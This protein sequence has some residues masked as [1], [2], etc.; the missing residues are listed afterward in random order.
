MTARDIIRLL[1]QK[2]RKDIFQAEVKTG[3]T[4]GNSGLL[5]LDGWAMKH[6]WANPLTIGYE[7][8]VSR[9]DF[10]GDDKW[11]LYRQYCDEFY[12]VAP[13]GIITPEELPEGVGL[14]LVSKNGR[15]L[16]TKRKAHRVEAK[17]E[18]LA[19]VYKYL[20]MY[21]GSPERTKLDRARLL[22]E[23]LEER[24]YG[25]ELDSYIKGEIGK[26]MKALDMENELQ[27]SRNDK[28]AEVQALMDEHWPEWR[29][30]WRHTVVNRVRQ[31]VC[32]ILPGNRRRE[33]RAGCKAL[34]AL[35]EEMEEELDG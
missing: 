11:H 12:F 20:L 1:E 23:R 15:R 10:L 13:P 35:V 14:M 26:R 19:D 3:A 33:L 25:R 32:A 4:H 29:D 7:V 31:R 28:L 22:R 34:L 9:A 6:S 17:A 24:R 27:R 8:K 30:E 21:R 5:K 18:Q 2:H 16:Y